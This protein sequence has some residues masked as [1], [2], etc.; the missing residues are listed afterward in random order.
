MA[1]PL[2]APRAQSAADSTGSRAARVIDTVIVLGNR[3]T[4]PFVILDEM[5]L[6][7]GSIATDEAIQYDR[8][9][10]YSLGLF[11]SVTIDYQRI[12]T[13]GFLIVDVNERWYLIP[14][15]IFGFR[16]G[17]PKKAFYGAGLIHTNFRGANQKLFFAF[18][19]G[20]DPS[21]A[22]EFYDPL[23][24]RE[25]HL[26]WGAGL[27]VSSVRNRSALEAA[28]A[29]DFDERHYD[30]HLL[31][32]KRFNLYETAGI[33]AGY[34]VAYVTQYRT[35]RTVSPTGRDQN[36][37]GGLEY[38]FDS[39]DLREYATRGG[40]YS[41]SATKY[42]FGESAVDFARFSIDL[43]R[44]VPLLPDLSLATRMYV[45]CITGGLIPS[46]ARTYVGYGDQR[47]RGWYT[48]VFEGENMGGGT[49]ELRYA[50]LHA[51]TIDVSS[52]PIPDE[53]AYWRFGINLAL[54]ADVGKAWFRGD[55][56]TFA[57]LAS[58]YG[59]GLHLLLPYSYVGRIEYAWNE[60]F[61]G[62]II[63]DLRG[64]I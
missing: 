18:T 17:D 3:K 52:L 37:Y 40:Y 22:F 10:I 46:Y 1:L 15:P 25:E 6:K 42:G 13:T 5:T 63:L 41:V 45:S 30:F 39:R 23:F 2:G 28:Y 31:L 51:R 33:R 62:Q 50:V 14:V 49:V 11:S 44:Y 26:Y 19:L 20:F 60:Y 7:P 12:D 27:S 35:G 4:K 34:G 16:D 48:T 57:T 61:R 56:L 36:L 54:F 59:G 53:F 32:G 64:S 43:R 29:G 38:V 21:V 47:V 8:G 55:R 24:D 9:R 58:G